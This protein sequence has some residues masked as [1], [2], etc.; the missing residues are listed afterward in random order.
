MTTDVF[1]DRPNTNTAT[2]D[3]KGVST[4]AASHTPSIAPQNAPSHDEDALPAPT[5]P[6]EEAALAALDLGTNNCRLLIARPDAE[7]FQV[8]DA[9]SRTVRLG[10]GLA[11]TGALS[12]SAMKRT[13]E[14]LHI[15]AAKMRRWHVK[16]AR[17]V[18][19][20]ACRRAVNCEDFIQRT[21]QETGLVIQTIS[22][23]E[24]ASLALSGCSPL[25]D[26]T[27]DR[28]L[29]FD[30]GG[31]STEISWLAVQ[32]NAIPKTLDWISLPMGVVTLTEEFGGDLI[33]TDVY[34]NIVAMV[35]QHLSHFEQKNQIQQHIQADRVQMLGTSGT[36][37]TLAGLH[38][39]L[40]RYSRSRVDGSV[41]DF[42]H[43]EA[44]STKLAAMD[45][46]Q[47]ASFPCIG[48]ERADL[49]VSGCAILASI[50][51]IWPV[52]SLRVADRGVREGILMALLEDGESGK[53]DV[54]QSFALDPAKAP[55]SRSRKRSRR[56]GKR[57][58]RTFF[59]SQ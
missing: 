45:F 8:L 9:F 35:N 48:P 56:G 18:A 30:I 4:P 36:V 10:E 22:S 41:L 58:K 49:V 52:G 25:L 43:V 50:R 26:H 33:E 42:E 38:L 5:E 40:P 31:G 55:S 27:K 19:T 1:F 7:T 29:V 20:E 13:I 46:H 39:G 37:T 12:E 16:R 32:Q 21:Y 53:F 24:E 34:A 44:L 28:A 3:A 57:R 51:Q 2:M 47:R 14:A 23:E 59:S 15:C 17:C 6:T 54:A 11:A